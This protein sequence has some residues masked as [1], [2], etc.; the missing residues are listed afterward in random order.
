[1][2]ALKTTH[3]N[4]RRR[5]D[6]S[7]DGFD[8][9]ISVDASDRRSF[10]LPSRAT[11][12]LDVLSDTA[13]RPGRA[14]LASRGDAFTPPLQYTGGD[15]SP[16][17]YSSTSAKAAARSTETKRR[18][19]LKAAAVRMLRHDLKEHERGPSVC[20]CGHAA[21]DKDEKG[22]RTEVTIHRNG[23][24][25]AW[26]SGVYRCKSNWLCP[27]C[28]P[29][30]AK[31]RQHNVLRVVEATVERGGHFVMGLVTLSHS[32]KDRLSDLKKMLIDSFAAARRGAPWERTKATADI[33]GVLVAVEVTHGDHG[34][35]IHIHYGM[36]CLSTDKGD[37]ETAGRTLVERFMRQVGSRGGK[38]TLK[39]QGWEVAVSPEAAA[40]YIAKGA[41][42]ELAGTA[43]KTDS[44]GDTIWDIVDDADQGDVDAFARFKEY[45][46]VMPG[47][48]SCIVTS[49]MRDRLGLDA[50]D[51]P[52][53][54]GE[55]YFEDDGAVV[56]YV[57]TFTWGRILR[58]KLVGTFLDRIESIEGAILP[59]TFDRIVAETGRDADEAEGI[60][61]LKRA[62][63]LQ[64]SAADEAV[65]HAATKTML[66]HNIAL[67][68]RNA[69]AHEIIEQ[70]IA[71]L[72]AANYPEAA[73][74][75]RSEVVSEI[76][77]LSALRRAA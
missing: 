50:E 23:K 17:N 61:T 46:E 58:M 40:D 77:R 75:T 67:R 55:Q 49:R 57:E 35:H 72:R 53:E 15:K 45:A 37:A 20:G 27:T 16:T 29:A 73:L 54:P 1:M 22:A 12:K 14:E 41:A 63:K 59:E 13:T 47:T 52:D 4:A 8:R 48:R 24:N 30:I 56:G 19:N 64:R 42:W 7:R 44:E 68:V 43:H 25:R 2:V 76:S 32:K 36:P 71:S 26:V 65:G 69:L 60:V 31:R 3:V 33:A 38:T 21:Y 51:V 34:W 39:A 18:W 70:Q 62:L 10:A 74:P 5:G 6:I 66:T 28:A 9:D 11:E